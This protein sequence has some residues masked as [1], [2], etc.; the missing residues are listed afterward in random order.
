[1]EDAIAET[2]AGR[3]L[4]VVDDE[5]RENEGDLTIA[6]E[7]ITPEIINFMATHGRGLICLA[8]TAARCDY[9][10]LPPMTTHNTSN[11]GTAFTESIDALTGVTTGISAADRARTILTAI[12]PA[13]NAADLARPGHVFPLRARDGGVLVRAGQTEAAVDLARLAGL[14]PGGVIC[15][16]MNED[17]S[18]ARVPQLLEFC[19]RHGLKMVSVA[20]LIRY[21]LQHERYIHRHGE[22]ILRTQFGEFRM[23]SYASEVGSET[24]LALVRGDVS[25]REGVLVRMHSHC[26]FG[27]VFGST[28]CDC[29][30]LV[31]E[32]LRRI[33]E[34]GRG[35]LVYLH[36]TGPG[37]R[38]Q[39]ESGGIDTLLPH[40]RD[41]A[42]AGGLAA[43]RQMQHEIGIGAQILSD[44][45]LHRIRLLTN[46]PRKVV[47]LAGFGI[48][49][50]E[51]VPISGV[52]LESTR[53]K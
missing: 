34:E 18:M 32:S 28:Q 45:G 41:Q 31:H 6:A 22:G 48:H 13:T 20:D 37:M 21:R 51:Q 30:Q 17:G 36:Q 33:G 39:A 4:V 53:Q 5:D 23:I 11:F 27:D 14:A 38:I 26:V 29:H 25:G 1:M 8:L 16:I 35:V 50:E 47:A 2:R 49:I 40:D 9:L 12:D 3:M 19:E 44:L 43:Q 46:H 15:E 24:H 52:E 10:R 7:K 42:R